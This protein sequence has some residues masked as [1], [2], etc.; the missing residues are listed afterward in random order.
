MIRPT[1][2]EETPLLVTLTEAT[3]LFKPLE[4]EA[5][6]EVFADYFGGNW[7]YGHR[8]ILNLR[9]HETYTRFYKSQGTSP[10]FYVANEGKDPDFQYHIRG[11]GLWRFRP[12]LN[13]PEYLKQ[14]HSSRNL[15][16]GPNGLRP[17]KAAETAEVIYKVQGANVITSQSLN[18]RFT[19]STARDEAS[20]AVSVNNGLSWTEVGVLHTWVNYATVEQMHAVAK[21]VQRGGWANSM[22]TAG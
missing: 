10:E 5:L 1:T 22:W 17:A 16:G 4:V 18:A 12:E 2:P 11:N 21:L 6:V 9:P 20:I 19:R 13:K 15:A 7:D 14:I 3:G 8:Y